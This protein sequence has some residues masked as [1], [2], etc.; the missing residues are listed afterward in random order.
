MRGLR[1]SALTRAPQGAAVGNEG[2]E[3]VSPPGSSHPSRWRELTV[4]SASGKLP[5]QQTRWGG[6]APP[7]RPDGSPELRSQCGGERGAAASA[8]GHAWFPG[9]AGR[10]SANSREDTLRALRPPGPLL[11]A[12]PGLHPPGNVSTGAC[13]LYRSLFEATGRQQGTKQ[14]KVPAFVEVT[15]WQRDTNRKQINRVQ[16]R[17]HFNE[18]GKEIRRGYRVTAAEDFYYGRGGPAR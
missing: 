3:H 9:R 2:E 15:F 18:N 4:D 11:Q 10:G 14:T 6:S 5:S 12:G 17:Q 16:R 7:P 8:S 13:G 1:L